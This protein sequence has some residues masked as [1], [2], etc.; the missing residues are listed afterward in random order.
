MDNFID[1]MTHE[2]MKNAQ[3]SSCNHVAYMGKICKKSCILRD[4]Q[5]REHNRFQ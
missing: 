3:Y 2:A 4:Q 5:R 1:N